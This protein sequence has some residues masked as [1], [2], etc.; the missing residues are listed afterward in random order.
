[1]QRSP[2]RKPHK[3]TPPNIPK[4]QN[5]WNGSHGRQ[6]AACGGR[7]TAGGCF[8]QWHFMWTS[9]PKTPNNLSDRL[10]VYPAWARMSLHSRPTHFFQSS[11]VYAEKTMVLIRDET[12]M[13]GSI[14][15]SEKSAELSHHMMIK[16]VWYVNLLGFLYNSS[17][18]STDFEK[19]T[20]CR[21]S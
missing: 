7:R 17:N 19:N 9:I 13:F 15:A 16:N 1:M 5:L 11:D 12:D 20:I 14:L 8:W 10:F 18:W 3:S 4:K 2:N 21:C 6:G